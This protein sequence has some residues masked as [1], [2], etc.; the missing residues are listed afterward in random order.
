MPE[1]PE[2]PMIPNAPDRETTPP[3]KIIRSIRREWLL[4]GG[5]WLVLFVGTGATLV[6]LRSHAVD[7]LAQVESEAAGPI[8]ASQLLQEQ[9]WKLARRVLAAVDRQTAPISK[10]HGTM[11]DLLAAEE[12]FDRAL[13]IDPRKEFDPSWASTYAVLASLAEVYPRPGLM[14]GM[15]AAAELTAGRKDLAR[16]LATSAILRTHFDGVPI[17]AHMTLLE[18]ALQDGETTEVRRVADLFEKAAPAEIATAETYRAEAAILDKDAEAGNRHFERALTLQPR[19]P[20]ETRY[21]LAENYI[22]L[23]RQSDAT[24]VLAEGLN[25]QTR[26]DPTYLH[27]TGIFLLADQRPTEAM[28]ILETARVLAPSN[29]DMLWTQSRAAERSGQTRRA[30]KLLQQALA[31]NPSIINKT[32]DDWP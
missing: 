13:R 31:I 14:S 32:K 25:N 16:D 23:V 24:R 6:F 11:Q 4:V 19:K 28:G 17:R 8:L 26:R 20:A 12:C 22:R 29:A 10:E 1:I 15:Q 7:F 27:R 21:R 3:P 5:L 2:E 30:A 9:G 18:I